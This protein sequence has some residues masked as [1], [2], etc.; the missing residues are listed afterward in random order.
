[1]VTAILI[2][3]GGRGRGAYGNWALQNKD[4]MNFVA[5]ADPNEIR[6]NQFAEEHGI[7]ENKVYKSWENILAQKKMADLCVIATQDQMHT[8]PALKALD[9]G[10]HVMLE[11]P[12]ATTQEE[13]Y[14]ISKKAEET[15][16]Q[17]W[18]AHVLR[19]TPFFAT[20]KKALQEGE[21]GEIINI[22]HSENISYWHFAHSYVRGKWSCCE[23]SSPLVLAKTSHDLDILY[24]LADSE[25]E[26]ISSFG[27]LSFYRSENAPPGATARCME[28]CAVANTCQWYAPRV[29]LQA[30]P[31]LQIGMRSKYLYKRIIAWLALHHPMAVS[32]MGL[33]YPPL[34]ILANRNL[35]PVSAITDDNTEES[36]Y[37][38][39]KDGPY[40][41][42]VFYCDN[43]V[44][45]NQVV[46]I[47]FKNGIT[48]SL[49]V[50]GMASYEGRWI[51]VEGSRGT[52]WGKFSIE[53]QQIH[54]YDHYQVR[55]KVLLNVDLD[56]SGHMGGDDGIMKAIA[57]SLQSGKTDNSAVLTSGKTSLESHFMAFAAEKSRLENEVVLLDEMRNKVRKEAG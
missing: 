11:K 28:G 20:I 40:G 38:A 29:Y 15:G 16:K 27:N 30:E 57:D 51:R 46:N 55:K 31:V 1:M 17:L 42:C 56:L 43:D 9:L 4:K 14:R 32:F 21:I 34:R 26:K 36:K 54:L 23:K 37:R 47:E 50:H 6:R 13:C 12:M 35:W 19:Y 3:A 33:F 10:Y 24:W 2:G 49:R 39:I 45:D 53:D 41:R 25:A 52:L 48:A 8:G 7:A 5:V 22:E 18:I 44:C